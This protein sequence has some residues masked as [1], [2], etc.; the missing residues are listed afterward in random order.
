MVTINLTLLIELGLFLLFL[1]G[2]SKFIFPRVI[3]SIEERDARIETNE[4]A[5]G[6]DTDTAVELEDAYHRRTSDTHRNAEENV[7]KARRSAM[8]KHAVSIARERDR[9]DRDVAEVRD[10]AARGVED[11]REACLRMAPELANRMMS[12]LGIGE[13]KQ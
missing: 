1:W 9:A 7:R 10:A 2:T 11:E 8:D 5:A 3:H 6:T 13:K 12:R 4:H